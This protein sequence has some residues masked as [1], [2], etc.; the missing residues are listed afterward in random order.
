[1][2]KRTKLIFSIAT[3]CSLLGPLI[4][5]VGTIVA[6]NGGGSAGG[7][8]G[9]GGSSGCMEAGWTLAT[10]YGAVWREY[11]MTAAEIA[12][13]RVSVP[14]YSS[15]AP[16]GEI[17][18]CAEA[19]TY[20]RYAMVAFA[21]K[22]SQ[23][24][25]AGQQVGIGSIGYGGA[26]SSFVS[27]FFGGG[28]NYAANQGASWAD[29]EKALTDALKNPKFSPKNDPATG[30]QWSMSDSQSSLGWF[31]GWPADSNGEVQT[32]SNVHAGNNGSEYKTTSWQKDG[33]ANMAATTT[34]G[35]TVYVRFSH[36]ARYTSNVEQN[37][38]IQ[39]SITLEQ[40][41]SGSVTPTITGSNPASSY[42][43]SANSSYVANTAI[44]IVPSH[45]YQLAFPSAATSGSYTI[46]EKVTVVE[47]Y[48]Y[49]GAGKWSG[50]TWSSKACAV[51]TIS[52]APKTCEELGTCPQTCPLP[53]SDYSLEYG[54]TQARSGVVNLTKDGTW[55]YTDGTTST[56]AFVWAKPGDTV[57]FTHTLCFGAQNVRGSRD[58][59]V[60]TTLPSDDVKPSTAN[61]ATITALTT[62]ATSGGKYLF[63]NTLN[64]GTTQAFTVTQ[65]SSKASS[66]TP[67]ESGNYWFT[68]YS[69]SN[70][71]SSTYSCYATDRG[72]PQFKTSGYQ[73]P[74]FTST[75]VPA[76]C[77]SAKKAS[78]NSDAG[79]II[80]QNLTWND[81]KSWQNTHNTD[82]GGSCTC[83]VQNAYAN[84]TTH[85][86]EDMR[87]GKYSAGT[88]VRK[89]YTAS[90]TGCGWCQ[91]DPSYGTRDY[92]YYPI[93]TTSSQGAKQIAQVK[94]PFNYTTKTNVS[95]SQDILYGGGEYGV[96]VTIDVNKRTN[97]DVSTN[98]YATIS[99]NSVYEVVAFTVA[100]DTSFNSIAHA[101]DK[102]TG[103]GS[104]LACSYYNQGASKCLSVYRS[105]T[106]Q[107]NDEGSLNG[108]IENVFSGD[109]AVPDA[110]IGTKFCVAVGVWPS[111][112]HNFTSGA[113][114]TN[115][116]ALDINSGTY[117][118]YSEPTCRTIT[119]KPTV[120]FLSAGAYTTGGI[121]TSQTKKSV[122]YNFGDFGSGNNLQSGLVNSGARRVFGSFTEYETI[123]KGYISGFASG[124]GFGYG[125]NN[126]GDLTS[127]TALPGGYPN[128]L[129]TTEADTC[130]YS[131]QTFSNDRCSDKVTGAS[132]INSLGTTIL[133][134]L[135]ARYTDSSSAVTQNSTNIDFSTF[136]TLENGAKY[137]KIDGNAT[138]SAS[139]CMNKGNVANSNTFVID[140]SGSLTIGGN[141]K[142]GSGS[143]NS[144]NNE[145]YSNIAE[146][147]QMIIFA[148]GINIKSNVTQIDAWLISGEKGGSS[149]NSINTCSDLSASQVGNGYTIPKQT[150]SVPCSSQ[151]YINGPVYAKELILNRNAG[152]GVGNASIQAAEIFNLRPDTYL[153]AYNQASRFSQAVTTYQREL[154]PRY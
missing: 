31:C 105:G 88:R 98:E 47:N 59:G 110:E 79:K 9:S 120:Q 8:G 27:E 11:T 41:K 19:G 75:T 138:I 112:S 126:G 71:S 80:E 87:G 149:N 91:R 125:S 139:Y 99:K 70:N 2:K 113:A 119:K 89:C 32:Q 74:D 109:L 133:N 48:K 77:N 18:G 30:R 69:P 23:G 85:S 29:A 35:G 50:G 28:M 76:N 150:N 153:W 124:A 136:K 34:A 140:V 143:G 78:T 132:S 10:C 135:I 4:I 3:V 127:S 17:T 13:D 15:Y 82:S 25:T 51:I 95:T 148:N 152:A 128:V 39:R 118:N 84:N 52:D 107:L 14:H 58:N 106:V 137:I 97:T 73:I 55:K 7:G 83:S 117:W 1:M 22:P 86:Y 67:D 38:T 65:G 26:S 20:W 129:Y 60:S 114:G 12:A 108:A 40:T 151:L 56:A 46:C 36:D 63:G 134:R 93:N 68:Y 121:T 96:N 37:V 115:D 122:S 62:P 64:G 16:G 141:L 6:A 101:N 147:P 130:T 61:T 111:D 43:F 44:S 49:E 102:Y 142:Y 54:G 146:L 33:V 53:N 92:K 103:T 116:T 5:G 104:K 123:A 100:P 81:V 42:T 144:C 154:S 94:I 66:G 21:N 72:F 90:S 145:S 45:T 24:I 131:T 57:K